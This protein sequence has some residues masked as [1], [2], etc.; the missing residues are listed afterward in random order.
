MDANVV[1]ASSNS[2]I[3]TPLADIIPSVTIPELAMA[4][5]PTADES[6]TGPL[7]SSISVA[8]FAN[9]IDP[10]AFRLITAA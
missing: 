9:T 8:S 2:E 1:S 7:M 10:V 4:T 5:W 6:E 3:L